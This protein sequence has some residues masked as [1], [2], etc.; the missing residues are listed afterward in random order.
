MTP[1][2]LSALRSLRLVEASSLF[3]L[4]CS[5][6]SSAVTDAS[7]D[8]TTIDGSQPSD[9]SLDGDA[10]ETS[11]DGGFSGWVHPGVL[12]N[13]AGLD[14][15]KAQLAANGEP[16]TSTLART[17][18]EEG[19]GQA[20]GSVT[21]TAHPVATIDCTADANGCS[22]LL[23]DGIAAYTSA[24]TYYYSTASTRADYAQTAIAI[25]NAWSSTAK[26]Y[27]G[28]QA[29]LESAWASEMFPRAAEIIRY[30]YTPGPS[31]AKL[32]V[33]AFS[34][35]LMNVFKPQLIAGAPTA[36]GNW[37]L[38]MA[39]GL[40]DIGVFTEDVPTFQA[41]IAMWKARTP[42][43]VYLT[44]DNGGNGRPY[45]PPGGQFPTNTSVDCF[46]LAS[47]SPVT[48]CTIPAGFTYQN[49]MVQETCRDM[50]HVMLGMS[51]LVNAAETARIQG[52]DLYGLEKARI[53]A[54][55]VFTSSFDSGYLT[56]NKWPMQ[57]CGGQP[58]AYSPDDAG[59]DGVGVGYMLGWEIAYNEYATR[60][61]LD[62]GETFSFITTYVRPSTYKAANQIAWESLTSVGTP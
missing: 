25:M 60:L 56:T 1:G 19:N 39:D 44:T 43:Y 9:A 51:S 62:A 4:A 55:Y 21:Y 50:T 11:S 3:A 57:P 6:P 36:N 15:V 47:G 48:S 20:F 40:I 23:Y 7:T 17:T 54:A 52:I 13:L 2:T 38:S 8:V 12:V 31:D 41:G 37:E 49:G 53:V 30:T 45:P 34:S 27:N 10:S 28:S 5:S 24:L 26:Q 33:T 35:M 46:W 16:W 61:G 58:S 14:F 42:A 59:D 18:T 29:Q 22:S 32:D